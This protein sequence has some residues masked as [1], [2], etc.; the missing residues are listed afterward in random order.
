MSKRL[1]PIN[2]LCRL[3]SSRTPS[4]WLSLGYIFHNIGIPFEPIQNITH[5]VTDFFI[6]FILILASKILNNIKVR[7]Y[8]IVIVSNLLI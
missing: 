5:R 8:L 3:S 2:N 6:S 1:F 7:T 4:V